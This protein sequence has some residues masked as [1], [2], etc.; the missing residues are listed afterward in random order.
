MDHPI[1][2]HN[3]SFT[4]EIHTVFTYMGGE[5]F[6]FRGDDDVWVYVGGKLVIDLGGIHAAEPGTVM[7]DTLGLTVGQTYPLDFFSAERHQWGSN[8]EFTTTIALH[9][10]PK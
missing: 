2:P 8:V 4:V 7:L 5:Y 3:Y 6:N 1:R 9:P 10:P